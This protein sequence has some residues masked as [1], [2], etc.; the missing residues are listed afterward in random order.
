MSNLFS[1]ILNNSTMLQHQLN[2]LEK[3]VAKLELDKQDLREHIS[4]MEEAKETLSSMY[5]ALMEDYQTV[6]QAKVDLVNEI[7]KLP[8]WLLKLF[9]VII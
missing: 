2:T 1:E 5:N 4:R 6:L 3:E 9:N 7:S 8:P